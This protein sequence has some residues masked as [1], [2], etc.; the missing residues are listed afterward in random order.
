M[1][2]WA[3]AVAGT[4]AAEAHAK[5]VERA[6]RNRLETDRNDLD[7]LEATAQFNLMPRAR[8]HNG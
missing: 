4:Q 7:A 8:S 1:T 3:A 5:G 2:A 6:A